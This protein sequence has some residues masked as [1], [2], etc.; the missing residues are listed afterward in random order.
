M[1]VAEFS[2]TH[3]CDPDWVAAMGEKELNILA[4]GQNGTYAGYPAT[5]IRHYHNGM[6]EI[7]VPGGTTCVSASD[8][9]PQA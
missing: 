6:Y 7:R 1:K 5:V 2:K 8:F 4:P 9:V 3:S